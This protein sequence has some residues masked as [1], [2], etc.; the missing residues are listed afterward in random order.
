MLLW[1]ST[2]GYLWLA[3]VT[4]GYLWLPVVTCGYLWLP[5]ATCGYLYCMAVV[6]SSSPLFFRGD[7]AFWSGRYVVALKSGD[8]V[9]RDKH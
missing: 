4:C 1:T 3:V 6:M 5:V 2:R 7:D 9:S 8:E